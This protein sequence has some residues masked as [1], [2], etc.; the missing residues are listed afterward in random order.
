LACRQI[1]VIDVLD[2]V[3]HPLTRGVHW[4]G[5]QSRQAKKL[6]VALTDLP[7]RRPALGSTGQ[8][9][10]PPGSGWTAMHSRTSGA[11]WDG[12]T[13]ESA[14][15]LRLVPIEAG[16]TRAFMGQWVESSRDFTVKNNLRSGVDGSLTG[17]LT[18]P[19]QTLRDAILLHARWAWKLGDLE[20]G[21]T[22]HVSALSR[23][24]FES[25]LRP[26]QTISHHERGSHWQTSLPYDPT[27]TEPEPIL[28]A[29]MFYEALGGR[30]YTRLAHAQLRWLD[31][32]RFLS[33]HAILL[34]RI[35][36]DANRS[37]WSLAVDGQPG[38]EAVEYH[39]RLTLLRVILP[40][41]PADRK[42]SESRVGKGDSPIFLGGTRKIGTV[43]NGFRIRSE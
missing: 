26:T 9:F 18:A 6:D 19:D 31:L 32:S 8:W 38:V 22:V 41:E 40:I 30:N 42:V 20:P 2:D 34:A 17:E 27:G 28:R 24:E 29:M 25:A 1:D 4:L 7:S 35:E 13:Y 21:K 16:S 11:T 10:A 15:G 37:K 33:T 12:V 39:D 36:D 14:Q 23:G 43:P 3:D 5:V